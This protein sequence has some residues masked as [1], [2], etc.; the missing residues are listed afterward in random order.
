MSKI[1]LYGATSGYIELAAPA[2]AD[3]ATLVL[4]TGADG[5]ASEAYVDTAVAPLASTSYVDAAVAGVGPLGKV[6]QVVSTTKTS[7]QTIANPGATVVD[8][9]GLSVSITPSS[10]TSK[11]LVFGYCSLTAD[12]GYSN[13]A[14]IVLY[15]DATAISI[16]N[17]SGSKV[18]ATSGGTDGGD[19]YGYANATFN[20]LDSPATT[21]AT[22]YKVAAGIVQNPQTIYINRSRSDPFTGTSIAARVTSTITAMEI[23]A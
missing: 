3:D 10:A 2:V 19:S 7:T 14:Y 5:F 9:S 23:G 11:V 12:N 16:G 6:L 18:R 8:V 15:R 22:T 20:F 21:S 4:P 17:A 1:R 13:G